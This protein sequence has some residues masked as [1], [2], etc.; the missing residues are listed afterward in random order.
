[1]EWTGCPYLT[2]EPMTPSSKRLRNRPSLG[3]NVIV[4]A[5]SRLPP[6]GGEFLMAFLHGLCCFVAAALSFLAIDLRGGTSF[7]K[8]LLPLI[9][10]A[11][12]IAW[13][14]LRLRRHAAKIA[15]VERVAKLGAVFA[16]GLLGIPV[17][18][19]LFGELMN[20]DGRDWSMLKRILVAMPC[21]VLVCVLVWLLV[22]LTLPKFV[23]QDGTLC[24]GCAYCLIGVTEMRCPECGRE[25]TYDEIETTAKQFRERMALS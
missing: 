9:P 12:S 21:V 25:F 13:P 18:F 19:I 17:L 3:S 7:P 11:L 6:L 4:I 22:R 10:V 23:M 24:P 1:M 16:I 20:I 14:I 15:S 5:P 2:P 8:V